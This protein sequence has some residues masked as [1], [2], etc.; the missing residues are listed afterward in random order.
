MELKKMMTAV[1]T[2]AALLD[3]LLKLLERETTELSGVDIAAMAQTNQAKEDLLKKISEHAQVMQQAIADM[4]TRDG[5]APESPFAV[6]AEHLA[7]GGHPEP[8]TWQVRLK[9]TAE[10]I[11]Q[12]A[13][14]NHGIAERFSST[15]ATSLNLVTRI[16]NQSNV[17]GAT[18]GYQKNTTGAVMINREA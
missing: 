13:T 14:M 4:A 5:L 17:Y 3:E 2:Q 9:S 7:K 15:I 16:I 1:T 10:R 6:V 11:R 12:V 18:G 8:L